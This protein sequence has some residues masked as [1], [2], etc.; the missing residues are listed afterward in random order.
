M[1]WGTLFAPRASCAPAGFEAACARLVGG[2]LRRDMKGNVI[3]IVEAAYD[4]E[5]D[6][7]AWLARLLEQAEPQLNHNFGVTISTYAPGMRL[8]ES[9]VDVRQM[10][11]HVRNAMLAMARTHP[12]FL[13]TMNALGGG[14]CVTAS[15]RLSV[16]ADNGKASAPL[17]QYMHPVGVRDSFGVLSLD[18]SGHAIWL[19]ALLP[20]IH[21]PSLQE[22]AAW[23]R[24]AA[25]ISAGARLRR[26]VAG[27]EKSDF[28]RGSDA[29]ISPSGAIEHAE[30]CAQ[31]RV[32]PRG[33][34]LMRRCEPTRRDVCVRA[35][36]HGHNGHV[37]HEACSHWVGAR[38]VR[39]KGT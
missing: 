29:V 37:R 14:H 19:G 39:T 23:S 21:R 10:S 11:E 13:Q 17:V 8:D 28:T 38:D 34:V 18:P 6:D 26:S 25:H 3:S 2:Q 24:I 7:R 33:H 12:A 9:L 22:C 32:V 4:L 15:Q 27:L 20:N 35:R 1:S 31:G 36:E 16:I 30:P 5:P